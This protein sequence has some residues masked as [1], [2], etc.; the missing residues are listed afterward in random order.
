MYPFESNDSSEWIRYIS[1]WVHATNSL[2]NP[3]E[4][5][6]TNMTAQMHVTISKCRFKF[7]IVRRRIS[8]SCNWLA[9]PQ[10]SSPNEI[11]RHNF[12]RFN[13]HS[14]TCFSIPVVKLL[15]NIHFPVAVS[16]RSQRWILN[17]LTIEQP[18]IS[19]RTLITYLSLVQTFTHTFSGQNK[20]STRVFKCPTS[21]V[22]CPPNTATETLHFS[23]ENRGM[24]YGVV[25]KRPSVRH[26]Q[27]S[28]ATRPYRY[29]CV[30]TVISVTPRR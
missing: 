7:N 12:N 16:G 13:S 11:S 27:L 24:I 20:K 5:C 29:S 4:F 6:S 8:I 19:R 22:Q 21:I 10:L 9:W 1:V 26:I 30:D 14:I 25:R 23:N 2:G 18:I 3:N 15:R 17:V 28:S